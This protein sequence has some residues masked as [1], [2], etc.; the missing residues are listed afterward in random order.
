MVGYCVGDH[1]VLYHFPPSRSED[2]I[3]C[4]DWAVGRECKRTGE[5]AREPARLLNLEQ[6]RVPGLC[7][8]VACHERVLRERVFQQLLNLREVVRPVVGVVVE[9]PEV[10]YRCPL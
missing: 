1:P 2:E 8:E 9:G 7:I 4:P 5:A 10:D 3:N 6:W